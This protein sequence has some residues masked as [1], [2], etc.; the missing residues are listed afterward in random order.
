M[1]KQTN[2]QVISATLN[3]KFIPLLGTGFALSR[4]FQE[5]LLLQQQANEQVISFNKKVPFDGPMCFPA[6]GRHKQWVKHC[7][8]LDRLFDLQWPAYKANSQTKSRKEPGFVPWM[9]EQDRYRIVTDAHA[10]NYDMPVNKKDKDR[11][12]LA[13]FNQQLSII[14]K[15]G[16]IKL[17]AAKSRTI[18]RKELV[19]KKGKLLGQLLN[20]KTGKL[21]DHYELELI[22]RVTDIAYYV[23][24]TA[25]KGYGPIRSY[26][27]KSNKPVQMILAVPLRLAA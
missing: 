3:G 16:A 2:K 6:K 9:A 12:L 23:G 5:N 13:T 10:T 24:A 11:E 27:G 8:K 17:V 4:G 26:R 25:K 20:Q 1:N 15:L 18:E 19:A 14:R 7:N 21:E 22:E